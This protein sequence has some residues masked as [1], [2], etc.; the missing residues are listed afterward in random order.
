M[1][2]SRGEVLG[3]QGRID[4]AWLLALDRLRVDNPAAV[5][6]LEYAAFLAPEPIPIGLF[7]D[8]TDLLTHPCRTRTRSPMRSAQ[9]S[10][11]H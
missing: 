5:Q 1:L 4:T 7:T 11:T 8:H 3:Y 9:R 6:L 10:C 2:L